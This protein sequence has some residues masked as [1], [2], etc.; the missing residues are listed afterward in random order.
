MKNKRTCTHSVV[1]VYSFGKKN[2]KNTGLHFYFTA[3][4]SLFIIPVF[5]ICCAC[6]LP[7]Y[8]YYIILIDVRPE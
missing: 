6:R 7:T 4:L 1:P 8:V 2:Q 5:R 3:F